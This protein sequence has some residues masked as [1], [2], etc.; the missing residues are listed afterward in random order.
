MDEAT[1]TCS[2]CS[3]TSQPIDQFSGQAGKV[4]STCLKCRLKGRKNDKT[5]KRRESHNKL[6]NE[7]KY[8]KSWRENKL[9]EN[10]DEFRT[11]NNEIHR[12]W[13]KTNPHRIPEWFRTSQ[14]A[15]LNSIKYSA[16]KREIAWN[17]EDE[18]AMEMMLMPCVYCDY[19]NIEVR[20]N[21]I[22]R[23]DSNGSYSKENCVPCCKTCNYMKCKFD[24]LTFVEHCKK[25][26]QCSFQFPDVAR[27]YENRFSILPSRHHKDTNPGRGHPLET[28]PFHSHRA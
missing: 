20:V 6:Q 22:D 11:H 17:L 23:M 15:R 27:C 28:A 18:T 21:G 14:R 25:V 3:R 19:V 26:A 16:T 4:F 10:P 2:A 13:K 5:E 1:K 8:Y 24:P 9:K 12:E 7:K